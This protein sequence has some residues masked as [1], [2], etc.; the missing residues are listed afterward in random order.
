[1]RCQPATA[2]GFN[3]PDPLAMQ[4]PPRS[5]HE[6]ILST[7]LL[8][9]YAITGEG[10]CVFLGVSVCWTGSVYSIISIST[11][12]AFARVQFLDSYLLTSF[13]LC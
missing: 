13:Q 3:P 12:S 6:P 10:A 7:W 11:L 5:R 2:L 8:V 9:R 1:V 4:Q